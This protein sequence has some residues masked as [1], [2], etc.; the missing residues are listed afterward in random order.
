MWSKFCR[1]TTK[2]PFTYGHMPFGFSS[3]SLVTKL[4][5][6]LVNIFALS[7]NMFAAVTRSTHKVGHKIS[8]KHNRS[9]GSTNG[10]GSNNNAMEKR[11][12]ES[13]HRQ[14]FM[15][16]LGAILTEVKPGQYSFNV[17]SLNS[18]YTISRL[19]RNS[20]EIWQ[21]LFT[22]TWIFPW[23]HNR[24]LGGWDLANFRI[25]ITFHLW[26]DNCGGYASYTLA[27][28]DSTVLT[29]EY[30]LN[31]LNPADG[32]WLISRGHVIKPGKLF[33]SIF[34][35]NRLTIILLAGKTLF[36]TRSDVFVSKNGVE[37]LCATCQQTV[38]RLSGKKDDVGMENLSK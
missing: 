16:H 6:F 1:G 24:H 31:I 10:D 27:S 20:I 15:N 21:K 30:K 35:H 22:A 9:Y 4:N 32:D 18:S 14:G 17:D 23:G 37:K 36:V 7:P 28:D 19:C 8:Y 11:V 2:F 29:V 33:I 34:V 25:W 13:F 5:K 12:R 3:V 38:M 26:L